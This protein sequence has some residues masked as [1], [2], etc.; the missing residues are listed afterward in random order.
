V[1][2]RGT[3]LYCWGLITELARAI[4]MVSRVVTCDYVMSC[5]DWQ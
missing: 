2:D 3:A 5:D 1:N 4:M